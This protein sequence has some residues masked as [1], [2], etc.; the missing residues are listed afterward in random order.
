MKMNIKILKLITG[1]EIIG[2][3]TLEDETLITLKNPLAIVIR[4]SQD[5]F[6]FG[7]MPWCSLIEGERLVSIGLSNVVTMGNPTDEV[8]NTYSSMFGGIVTPPKQ[9]IV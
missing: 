7:F 8:K 1:E 3:V 6:T 5:G 4:P 9:L 2:E